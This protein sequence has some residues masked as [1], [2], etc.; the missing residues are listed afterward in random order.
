MKKV[1]VGGASNPVA[2][3]E[4]GV[5]ATLT[6]NAPT[7]LTVVTGVSVDDDGLVT[8]VTTRQIWAYPAQ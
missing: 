4:G 5:D 1:S 7:M 3:I 8:A 2:T 6:L